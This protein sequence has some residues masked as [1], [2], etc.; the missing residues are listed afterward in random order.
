[1]RTNLWSLTLTAGA[2]A[3][4]QACSD[5]GGAT[6]GLA[7]STRDPTPSL[8][9]QGDSTVVA[10]GNDTI[11]I[12]SVELVLREIELDR[13]NDD[14]CDTI[15]VG[16]DDACE[17][18]ETGPM[19]VD[20]PLG[21]STDKVITVEVPADVYDELEFEIHKPENP[22]DAAFIAAHPTFAG[23]SIRVTGTYSQAGTRTNFTYITDLNAEQEVSLIPP[24]DIT[25]DGPVNLTIRIDLSTWF[26]NAAGTALVDPASANQ[27]GANENLVETNIE[28]SID[29]FHDDDA[30]GLDDDTEDDDGG[31]S[32]DSP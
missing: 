13:L 5:S 12:R 2:L 6:A 28:Q 8:V 30:D 19:L 24:L 3:L 27:G 23:V 20:L 25:A 22:E 10:L 11:I 9:Q 14:D 32:H 31:S 29:A 7:F 18:F 15:V 1:M 17:E 4:S 26:L 21:N 16:D